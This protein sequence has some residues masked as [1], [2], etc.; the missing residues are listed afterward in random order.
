MEK[1]KIKIDR[2]ALQKPRYKVGDIIVYE[3]GDDEDTIE[4]VQSKITEAHG[5]L[6][7]YD[8]EDKL[9]WFY[10]T[11]FSKRTADD[12]VMEDDILYKL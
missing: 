9:C 1:E 11:E 3:Y 6:W 4:L 7:K 12:E 10:T 5:M 8:Q 2:R